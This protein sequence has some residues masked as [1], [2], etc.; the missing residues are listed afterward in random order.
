MIKNVISQIVQGKNLQDILNKTLARIYSEGPVH[1]TDMEILSY[2]ATYRK[3]LIDEHMNEL[4]LYMGMY[5][6]VS[7]VEPQTLKELVQTTYRD[8][9][10]ADLG[11]V[12]HRFKL[13]LLIVLNQINVLAFLL[14]L[15]QE[16][17]TFLE[18]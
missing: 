9:I 1:I 17:R 15:V 8:V 2:F 10:K 3:E 4:L 6:K 14:Q 18:D 16:N 13:I 5:Y 11:E 7:D 12:I